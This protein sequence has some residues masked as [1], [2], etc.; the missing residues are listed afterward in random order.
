VYAPLL[1]E[2]YHAVPASQMVVKEMAVAMP[3]LQGSASDWLKQFEKVPSEL[4][5]S[6]SRP[7][8][9]RPHRRGFP[10]FSAALFTRDRL[11]ALVYYEAGCGGLCGEGG[12]AWFRRDTVSSPWRIEKKIVSR[13]S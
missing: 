3:T 9:T 6:A 10:A 12:Y 8:P 1:S 7:S 11:D 5:E 13:M 4:Y 2:R